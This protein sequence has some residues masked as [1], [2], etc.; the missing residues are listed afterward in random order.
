[1]RMGEAYGKIGQY[2]GILN[3]VPAGP[4]FAAYFNDDMQDLDVAIGF[5]VAHAL[6]GQDEIQASELP[7]GKVATCLH[8]GPYNEIEPAYNAL[9]AWVEEQGLEPTGVAYELY[10]NDPQTTAPEDL[11]TQIV[12]PLT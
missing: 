11:Q 3:E 5:P 2:L 10:L 6:E 4:P 12:Y 8:V 7:G 1:M 9:S